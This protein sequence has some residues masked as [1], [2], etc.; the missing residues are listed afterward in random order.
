VSI[1]AGRCME[2]SECRGESIAGSRY[3]RDFCAKCGDPIR[4]SSVDG[5]NFCS[6]CDEV[7]IFSNGVDPIDNYQDL[8]EVGAWENGIRDLEH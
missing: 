2:V 5:L 4:V 7:N 8:N 1:I 6:A 3:R